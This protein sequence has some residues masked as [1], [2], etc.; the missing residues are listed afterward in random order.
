[1]AS[2]TAPAAL[3]GLLSWSRWGALT[4]LFW[5]GSVRSAVLHHVTWS[6]NSICHMIGTPPFTERARSTNLWPLAIRSM[7]ESWHNLHHADPTCARHSVGRGELD[8]PPALSRCS[9][10]SGASTT[11]TGPRAGGYLPSPRAAE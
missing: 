7:G 10:S 3:G 6:I 4:A 1:V 11:S 8:I 5:A 2:L 9:K